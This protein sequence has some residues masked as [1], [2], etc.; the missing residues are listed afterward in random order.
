MTTGRTLASGLSLALLFLAP[1]ATTAAQNR[2]PESDSPAIVLT[3][4]VATAPVTIVE[5]SD[6]ECPFCG[7]STQTFFING[8][9]VGGAQSLSTLRSLIDRQLGR[10]AATTP[11][12]AAAPVSLPPEVVDVDVEGA[13]ARGLPLAPVTIVE[14]TDFQC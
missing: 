11:S 3:R 2:A 8:T 9:K 13:P 4:G 6:F 7:N 12:S 14:F 1:P 10:T 5:F